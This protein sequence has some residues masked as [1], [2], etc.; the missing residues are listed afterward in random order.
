M[1]APHEKEIEIRWRDLDVYGHVNH[2]VFLTYLEEARDEWLG[3]TLG[4][5]SKVWD[6]VIARVAID[7][8]RELSLADDGIVATCRLE[9][10]GTSSLRTHEE[11]VTAMG[12]RPPWR[13]RCSSRGTPRQAARARSRRPSALHSR[14]SFRAHFTMK[15]VPSGRAERHDAASSGAPIEPLSGTLRPC[16]ALAHRTRTTKLIMKRALRRPNSAAVPSWPA[17]LAFR[18]PL[19]VG[20]PALGFCW[21]SGC[22]CSSSA[23]TTAAPLPRVTFIGDSV[24]TGIPSDT[25]A[26]ATLRPGIDLQLQLAPCRTVAGTSCP[27]AGTSAPTVVDV[28]HELGSQLGPTVIVEAGYNDFATAFAGEVEQALQALQAAGVTH[29]IWLTLHESPF[30]PQYAGMN[31][32]LRSLAAGDPELTLADWNAVAQGHDDWFQTDEVH[33]YGSGARAMATLLVSTLRGLGIGPAPLVVT[34]KAVTEAR[35][36]SPYTAKL[37][38]TGGLAPYRWSCAPALPRG[39]H[40]L[41]GGRLTGTPS[42]KARTARITFTVTDISGEK[43]ARSVVLRIA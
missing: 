16:L 19:A 17:W 42:G 43:A 39:L 4:D 32:Q 15:P 7:Y 31:D 6:Y 8:K 38:A 23:P 9:R 37:A 18:Q 29:V 3:R 33:L 12:S 1:A 14:A 5:P 2:V 25:V 28:A 10:I 36:H 35:L 34:T 26:L 30:Q 24:G 21:P 22:R 41:A 20:A 13:R 40:L 27:Y 11:I